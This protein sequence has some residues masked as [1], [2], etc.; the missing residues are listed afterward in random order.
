MKN[1]NNSLLTLFLTCLKVGLFAFGGGYA[2]LALMENE[3]LEKRKWIEESEFTNVVAIAE[4]TPGPIAVNAATF[5][6]YKI[7]GFTGSIVA[8]V[9]VCLPAFSLMLLVSFFYDKFMDIPVIAS[10]FKGIQV[11]VIFIIGNV[12]Y[13]MLKKMKKTA[14]NIAFFILTFL[15]VITANVFIIHISSVYY[16]LI[17]AVSGLILHLIKAKKARREKL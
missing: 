16:I 13:K 17:C 1:K 15:C 6:G 8:T 3:F 12:G 9:G 11:S 5:V 10:A 14:F 2:I 7:K 4:S